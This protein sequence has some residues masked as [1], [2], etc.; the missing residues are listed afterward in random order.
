MA[1]V[2]D[3]GG[4]PIE[5]VD[6]DQAN[7]EIDVD[8][9][10]RPAGIVR[11]EKGSSQVLLGT[12]SDPFLL[13]S[14]PRVDD[15]ASLSGDVA[16]GQGVDCMAVAYEAGNGRGVALTLVVRNNWPTAPYVIDREDRGQR[17]L[18]VF[19]LF[20]RL[21]DADWHPTTV[22]QIER[23]W[24]DLARLQILLRNPLLDEH[25]NGRPRV[26]ANLGVCQR[27]CIS[28]MDLSGAALA[29][30]TIL[31]ANAIKPDGSRDYVRVAHQVDV[32][33]V[34]RVEKIA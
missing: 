5:V 28:A 4:P 14:Q 23:L 25:E 10:T 11:G 7:I 19:L 33:L 24:Y 1:D 26:I 2:A 32:V 12:H 30:P 8:V 27:T 6:V 31:R 17:P 21:Y 3:F 18:F 20:R 34:T 29:R 15:L 22:G 13:A 16:V 9:S